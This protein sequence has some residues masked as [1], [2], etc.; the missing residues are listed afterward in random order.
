MT[1]VWKDSMNFVGEVPESWI[2]VLV[3]RIW[4]AE[5][6]ILEPERDLCK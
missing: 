1:H 3:A 4:W 5:S 6:Q 2:L